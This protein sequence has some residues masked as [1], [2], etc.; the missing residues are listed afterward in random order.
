MAV[1]LTYNT[2]SGVAYLL[3]IG[4]GNNKVAPVGLVAMGAFDGLS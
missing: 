2:E 4:I 3:P 1:E